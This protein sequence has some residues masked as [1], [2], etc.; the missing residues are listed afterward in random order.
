MNHH[1]WPM[2]HNG[3]LDSLI[4]TKFWVS[5]VTCVKLTFSKPS[6]EKEL[7]LLAR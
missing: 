1:I 7:L 6:L 3:H 4:S 2:G 5:R